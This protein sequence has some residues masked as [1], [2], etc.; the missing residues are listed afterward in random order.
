MYRTEQYGGGIAMILSPKLYSLNNYKHYVCRKNGSVAKGGGNHKNCIKKLVYF[1]K[2][3]Y[4][5]SIK[6]HEKRIHA[7][8]STMNG[9]IVQLYE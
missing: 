1:P 3:N 2:F 8:N 7:A 9:K 6:C 4:F 5:R